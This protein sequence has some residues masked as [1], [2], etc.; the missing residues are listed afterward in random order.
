[1]PTGGGAGDA[2]GG[3]SAT[4]DAQVAEQPLAVGT[5]VDVCSDIAYATNP[6]SSGAHYPVWADFGV[7]DFPL[8]RGFWVHNLEHGAVVVTYNCPDGCADEVARAVAWLHGLTPDALCPAGPARALLVPDPKLD[9]RW[10]AS[11][12]GFTLRADCFDP[13]VFTAFYEARAGGA[14]A[15]EAVLCATGA[16]LRDPS[17]N[18]CG[19]NSQ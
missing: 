5:H 7:Y 11:A 10:G 17:A 16:D 4:C 12:W 13:A 8:P 9:A 14:E 3:T 6:P 19:A 1:M 15:P 18:T 2:A